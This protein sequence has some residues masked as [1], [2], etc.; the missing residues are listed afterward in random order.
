MKKENKGIEGLLPEGLSES[1]IAEIAQLVEDTIELRV[2]EKMSIV[3]AKV[4][5]FI[6]MKIEELKEHALLELQEENETYR[7]AKLF[8]HM[9]S[10][11]SLEIGESDKE[12]TI[13]SLLEEKNN[14]IKEFE[15]L[16]TRLGKALEENEKLTN[17]IVKMNSDLLTLEE[18]VQSMGDEKE[19]LIGE[20]RRLSESKKRPFKSSEK[21][22]IISENV[23]LKKEKVI[24]NPFLTP[25]VMEYMPFTSKK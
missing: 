21:A 17:A 16:S 15:E 2:K 6:R 10:V 20:V 18:H 19:E 23:E 12:S 4:K 9:K 8:E 5:S 1:S 24:S 7:N 11:I 3:E 14:K 13:S 22:V 25:E